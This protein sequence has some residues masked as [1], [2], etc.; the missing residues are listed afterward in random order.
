MQYPA[1][2]NFIFRCP[3]EIKSR[4]WQ[5]FGF[6]RMVKFEKL[7]KFKISKLCRKIMKFTFRDRN[8]FIRLVL[9]ILNIP[10]EIQNYRG[11][12][13][14]FFFWISSWKLSFQ[15]SLEQVWNFHSNL[16]KWSKMAK[17][18]RRWKINYHLLTKFQNFF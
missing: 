9:S 14:R 1:E 7:A 15:K 4:I 17:T 13:I 18:L 10:Q 16:N 11:S 6:F 5:I 3:T 8:G 2:K 12:R